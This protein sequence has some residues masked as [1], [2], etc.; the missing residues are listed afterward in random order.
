VKQKCGRG[1]P[2]GP[3]KFDSDVDLVGFVRAFSEGTKIRVACI[4]YRNQRGAKVGTVEQLQRRYYRIASAYPGTWR[5]EVY[6]LKT[7]GGFPVKRRVF[8]HKPSPAVSILTGRTWPTR[9]PS[10]Y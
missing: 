3:A 2:P 8:N 6:R 7:L 5:D 9:K 4:E 10:S 1:R